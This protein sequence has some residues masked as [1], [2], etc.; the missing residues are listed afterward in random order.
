MT[1]TRPHR[2]PAHARRPA[3]FAVLLVLAAACAERGVP[4]VPDVADAAAPAADGAAVPADTAPTIVERD[5]P[6][7]TLAAVRTGRRDGGVER[8]VFE[9][10]DDAL[11]GYA[12]AFEDAPAACGSGEPVRIAGAARLVVRLQPARAHSDAGE[13]TIAERRLAP[14]GDA[15][16]ELAVSCDFEA[17]LTWVLGL[18]RRRPYRVLT[19]AS[20]AR[21]VVDV[22]G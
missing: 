6:V 1:R 13:S 18:D 20:P 22:G 14:G 7:A 10:V 2:N 5:G 17:T 11:P 19:L 4:D 3:T 9:F 16:R 21:L 8:V 12:I 15:L